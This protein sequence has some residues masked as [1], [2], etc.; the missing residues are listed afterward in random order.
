M[1]I[2]III[3]DDDDDDDYPSLTAGDNAF[4]HIRHSTQRLLTTVT[5]ETLHASHQ[6]T[7]FIANVITELA[8]E[9]SPSPLSP[10]TPPAVTMY[11]SSSSSRSD[12]G[13]R[14]VGSIVTNSSGSHQQSHHTT[15]PSTHTSMQQYQQKYPKY[16]G[17][18]SSR[19][20]SSSSSSIQPYRSTGVSS[21]SVMTTQ[22]VDAI[23]GLEYAYSSVCRELGSAAET[24]I[25]IPIQQ[26]V[27]TGIIITIIT[28]I[29]IAIISSIIIMFPINII[30]ITIIII[31]IVAVIIMI[32][33]III[34]AGAKG[35]VKSVIRAMPL[36]ILRPMA[37][38][39]EGISLT[40]L[41]R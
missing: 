39:A 22:P 32:I 3:D 17:L 40:I 2:I 4:R 1:V 9:G 25:A 31:I 27:Q 24:V 16:H 28:I 23:T 5:R 8:S 18:S 29:I 30:I 38:I 33:T 41:G 26:Y 13:G 11:P 10:S 19:P 35:Y 37:G 36:A 21:A 12:G 6:F 15:T 20:S 34:F 14:A 7:K